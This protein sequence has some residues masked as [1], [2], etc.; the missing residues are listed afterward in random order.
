MGDS[1]ITPIHSYKENVC[2]SSYKR[3]KAATIEA[4]SEIDQVG[5]RLKALLAMEESVTVKLHLGKCRV[6]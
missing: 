5:K 2:S 6:L 1:W 4:D 3:C